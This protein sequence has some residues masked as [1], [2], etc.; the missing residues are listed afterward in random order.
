MAN[1]SRML[2]IFGNRLDR[3]ELDGTKDPLLLQKR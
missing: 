2:N 1:R 3:N